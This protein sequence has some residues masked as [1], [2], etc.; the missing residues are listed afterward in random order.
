MLRQFNI[1]VLPKEHG[2]IIIVIAV[3]II[4]YKLYKC[5]IEHKAF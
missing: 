5:A 3:I 1:N 2:I 4:V